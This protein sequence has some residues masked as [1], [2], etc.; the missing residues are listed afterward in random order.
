[1][2]RVWKNG[3]LYFIRHEYAAKVVLGGADRDT[4]DFFDH[5]YNEKAD[6]SS[7]KTCCEQKL[8]VVDVPRAEVQPYA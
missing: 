5:E 8:D 7:Q 2:S 4:S 3:R 1:M 6:F